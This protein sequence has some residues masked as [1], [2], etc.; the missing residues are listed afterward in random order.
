MK[1]DG[2][3]T[4][5]E[6]WSPQ[7]IRWLPVSRAFF[8]GE[9]LTKD[10]ETLKEVAYEKAKAAEQGQTCCK[11]KAKA[12][13]KS[14]AFQTAHEDFNAFIGLFGVVLENPRIFQRVSD[15]ASKII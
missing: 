7:T 4:K 2:Q 6:P 14:K 12:F 11:A 13:K 8:T 1:N 3:A 10:I 9:G 5:R 15:E